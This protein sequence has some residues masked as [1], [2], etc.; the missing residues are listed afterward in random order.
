M[1][2]DA[3]IVPSRPTPLAHIAQAYG[4]VPVSLAALDEH[5]QAQLD[6]FQPSFWYRHQALLPISMVGS[7]A[8]MASTGGVANSMLA[9][10]SMVPSYLT[11]AWLG[12]IGLLVLFGVFR[13]QAGSYWDERLVF[14][15][16]LDGLGVP[17]AIADVAFMLSRVMPGSTLILGELKQEEVVLDPYLLLGRGDETICLGIWDGDRVIACA[18]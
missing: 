10:G 17:P 1:P 5:K 15:G 4:I 9:P 2:F 11:L 7:V 12:V 18:G 8:C 3:L 16:E 14:V 13:L 6:R